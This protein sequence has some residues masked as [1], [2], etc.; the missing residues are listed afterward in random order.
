MAPFSF[1]CS[2][3][4][5]S[6]SKSP[7]VGRYMMASSTCCASGCAAAR[8]ASLSLGRGPR[9]AARLLAVSC[10]AR[11]RH[12][13]S[14]RD[15]ARCVRSATSLGAQREA[16]LSAINASCGRNSPSSARACSR[17]APSFLGFDRTSRFASASASTCRPTPH[18]AM[19]WYSMMVA[20]MSSMRSRLLVSTTRLSR[21]ISSAWSRC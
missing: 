17:Y 8:T 18:I 5:D 12:L 3:V 7:S 21:S 15:S 1:S 14:V 6:A 20:D 2:G 10:S 9:T 11:L 4:S 13:S 19:H 16:L